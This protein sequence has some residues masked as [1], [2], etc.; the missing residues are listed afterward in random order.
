MG[1]HGSSR[2]DGK[3]NWTTSLLLFWAKQHIYICLI[4][5]R[6][7][8]RK[9]EIDDHIRRR[10]FPR[11]F[12]R[13]PKACRTYSIRTA[14]IDFSN[15]HQQKTSDIPCYTGLSSWRS[16][17]RWF[18]FPFFF[19]ADAMNKNISYIE[20][21]TVMYLNIVKKA[22]FSAR[23]CWPLF[24]RTNKLPSIRCFCESLG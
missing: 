14:N 24:T 15:G 16:L 22:N 10:I 4:F 20:W 9:S 6:L 11:T 12:R 5:S 1:P 21:H 19:L 8:T 13:N 7:M 23:I 17:S 18:F 2:D 3:E